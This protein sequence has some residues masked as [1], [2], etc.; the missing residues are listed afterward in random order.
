MDKVDLPEILVA[1]NEP[2][3]SQKIFAITRA[4]L[5]DVLL[6]ANGRPGF[7]VLELRNLQ[8]EL[9]RIAELALGDMEIGDRVL[10][11][12]VSDRLGLSAKTEAV[13]MSVLRELRIELQDFL[14]LLH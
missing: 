7:S 13:L 1:P 10:S 4:L 3:E 12:D 14:S 2:N 8:R 9:D 6:V 5:W 11:E